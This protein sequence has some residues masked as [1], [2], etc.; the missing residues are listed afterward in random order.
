MPSF[1]P[2]GTSGG[3]GEGD[4]E[5]QDKRSKRKPIPQDKY[6]ETDKVEETRHFCIQDNFVD[7]IPEYPELGK[8]YHCFATDMRTMEENLQQNYVENEN[9]RK[10]SVKKRKDDRLLGGKIARQ[11]E[12][13]EDSCPAKYL[14]GPAMKY[15]YHKSTSKIRSIIFI[16]DHSHPT[17]GD[18]H[19][20]STQ[21]DHQSSSFP[22]EIHD[23]PDDES[24]P[25][26]ETENIYRD[27]SFLNR[28]NNGTNSPQIK[29]QTQYHSGPLQENRNINSI[30]KENSDE[31]N[32][33]IFGFS[34]HLDDLESLPEKEN[35]AIN[36]PP[37]KTK[38]Q[39]K[40][41]AY[42]GNPEEVIMYEPCSPEENSL[43]M[44][45]SIK[46]SSMYSTLNLTSN[47]E[48]ECYKQSEYSGSTA[49]G[50]KCSELNSDSIVTFKTSQQNS[51]FHTKT[52]ETCN[53]ND[54]LKLD[55]PV[56]STPMKADNGSVWRGLRKAFEGNKGT[57]KKMQKRNKGITN[58]GKNTD[59]TE[60]ESAQH[61]FTVDPIMHPRESYSGSTVIGSECSGL[62][63][64]SIV[65]FKKSQPNSTFHTETKETHK[66]ND[67]MNLDL[68]VTSTPMKADNGSDK[69]ELRK[70]FEGNKGTKKRRQKGNKG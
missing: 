2:A 51:T 68:P 1:N 48:D 67:A 53:V 4:I 39:V 31:S 63:S 3:A 37:S 23:Q 17:P 15:F 30:E 24:A 60:Q 52:Q 43:D 28:T 61:P 26:H 50:S 54:A 46:N 29:N 38:K 55:L 9:F 62:Y 33:T 14:V 40:Q 21:E 49:I 56:T 13:I 34:D 20:V 18:M 35:M 69:I 36:T 7:S 42:S 57:K 47:I 12:C 8:A 41:S 6:V 27:L 22:V 44:D 5:E 45:N 58:C 59:L 66:D 19:Q 32:S 70:A 65:T 11:F 64:D 10:Y 25:S 16:N